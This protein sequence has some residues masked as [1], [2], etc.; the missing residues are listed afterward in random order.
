MEK[1]V[2]DAKVL[3]VQKWLNTTY[4]SVAG[5]EKVTENGNTGWVRFIV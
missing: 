2:R 5:Y 4:S 1:Q 3:E